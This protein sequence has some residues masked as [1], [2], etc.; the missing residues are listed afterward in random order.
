MFVIKRKRNGLDEVQTTACIAG[1]SPDI[2]CILRNFRGMK[3]NMEKRKSL[4]RHSTLLWD[5][6]AK[7]VR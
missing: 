1:N 7:R 6:T 3:H 2:P 4:V 5:G